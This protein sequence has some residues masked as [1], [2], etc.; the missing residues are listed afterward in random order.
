MD[1]EKVI[2]ID[3]GGQY[4]QLVARRVRE[5]NVYCEIYSY[6]TDLEQIK[7]MNPK[8]IIL[9]GGPNSCYEAD[10]PT[11]QK[12]LFELG[13][14]VLGLCYGA[15]LMM[16]VL[17]GKVETPEVGEY[18]KTEVMLDQSCAL[19]EGLASKEICWMSHFDGYKVL[20][21]HGHTYGVKMS[22]MHLELHAKE[23]GADLALFGHTHKLFYDKHNGLAMMN[24]GSIGAPLWGCMPSY[25][26]I[27]FDKEHDVM[28]LD[29][30]YIEY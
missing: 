27:T 2:V 10:S 15:Q 25:G 3:F 28:K 19:F 21:C 6:K 17:G 13:I 12:E 14:P 4:N 1:Q 26:I 23:V 20:M 29:V 5:C 22:Y 11:Y 7:A 24:P 8:G 16:H 9:T 18:G 30:D